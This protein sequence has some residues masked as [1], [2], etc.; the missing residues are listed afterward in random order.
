MD[1]AY[2]VLNI[3]KFKEVKDEQRPNILDI[4]LTIE[5]LKLDISK[6]VNDEQE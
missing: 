6:E 1:V 5:V 4:D 3:V 2:E